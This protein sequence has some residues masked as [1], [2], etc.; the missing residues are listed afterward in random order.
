MPYV[1]RPVSRHRLSSLSAQS[2][3][4]TIAPRQAGPRGLCGLTRVRAVFGDPD[5]RFMIL[6]AYE[7]PVKLFGDE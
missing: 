2:V 6:R 3:A 4:E 7:G 1:L 5:G